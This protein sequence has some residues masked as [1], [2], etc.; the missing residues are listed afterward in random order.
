[1]T[2]ETPHFEF[3]PFDGLKIDPRYAELRERCPVTRMTPPYG[4]DAWLLT[5]HEDIREALSDPRFS[6][7]IGAEHD[8]ARVA[9]IP[10]GSSFVNMDG[11][12]HARLRKLVAAPF[13]SRNI[14][15][16]R[17]IA[18]GFAE[19]LLDE[20]VAAGPPA[21][22]ISSFTVPYAG[23]VIC[24]L[25]GVPYDDRLKFHNWIQA[26]FHRSDGDVPA[27]LA[28]LN[29][30]LTGLVRERRGKETGEDLVTA[31][32][33]TADTAGTYTEAELVGLI[34]LLLIG[35]YETPGSQLGSAV[36]LLLQ[37]PDQL[38]LLRERPE[39]MPGAVDE[40][41]RFVPLIAHAGFA[42]YA[43]EDVTIHGV[44]I[45]AGE[46]I[47]PG[48]ASANRDPAAFANPDELDI[49][50]THNPHLSFGH[51]THFCTGAALARMEM[52][53]ALSALLTKFHGLRI[54]GDPDVLPW[55][56]GTQIRSLEALPVTW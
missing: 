25:L 52:Q 20:M 46:A 50:R 23:K 53:E 40:L 31:M 4:E 18:R 5:R 2:T 11:R 37:N 44:T 32:L 8:E 36:F 30:Y 42:R 14:T 6:R 26:F 9:P 56:P 28:E 47:L 54:T 49:T 33:R 7:V 17:P 41:L 16:M 27:Q 34:Y 19:E 12:E 24:E 29:T 10:L 13:S 43:T 22:L 35:G 45:R 38:A 51:G 21:D 48:F 55:V 15:R 3:T 1:M 39:L